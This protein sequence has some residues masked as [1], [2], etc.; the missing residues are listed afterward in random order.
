MMRGL[1]VVIT[2]LMSIIFLGKKQNR[3]HWTGV[4][5]ILIGVF[6]VGYVSVAGGSSEGEG[7]QEI[8]GIMLLI[9]A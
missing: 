3:H 9:I 8:V 2:A 7:G 4:A 6:L 5:L 1:I